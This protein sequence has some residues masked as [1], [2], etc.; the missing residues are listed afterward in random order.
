MKANTNNLKSVIELLKMLEKM[1]LDEQ[2]SVLM[3]IKGYS[4]GVSTKNST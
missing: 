1:T 2:K 4:A 3:L